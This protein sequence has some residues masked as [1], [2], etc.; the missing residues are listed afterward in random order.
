MPHDDAISANR[1][2]HG[3]RSNKCDAARMVVGCVDGN[4]HVFL[5]GGH[6]EVWLEHPD[7]DTSLKR[8]NL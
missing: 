1:L 3:T 6:I 2:H 5:R 7:L 8:V 4:F